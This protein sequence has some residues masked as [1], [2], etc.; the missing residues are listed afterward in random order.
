[1]SQDCIFC[2]IVKGEI[3]SQ[4][5][6][7]NKDFFAFLDIKP[8]NKG[9]ALIVPKVH[10]ENILDF[11]K[12]EET[13]FIETIKV[14]A[15]ALVKATGADGFNVGMNNGEAAG[16]VV[17]HAHMHIIPRFKG[18]GLHTWPHKEF[19]KEEMDELHRKVLNELIKE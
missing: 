3:P 14:V 7:E 6:Y 19:S 4:K 10:C 13:D 5:I 17:L 11:P 12:A 8:I 1:M 15:K 9:H 16:Q 18:D 2:K